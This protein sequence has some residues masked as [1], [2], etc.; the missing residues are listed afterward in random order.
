MPT[1]EIYQFPRRRQRRSEQQLHRAVI[2]HLRWRAA[3]DVWFAHYPGGGYR[4]P[5][6]AAIL[7]SLGTREGVPDLLIVAPEVESGKRAGCKLYCIELKSSTGKLSPSQRAC[8]AELRR[9]GATVE[10]VS[11]IDHALEL[12]TAWGILPEASS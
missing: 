4:R 8:H 7:K 12:L 9:A 11:D 6:E 1:Q 3:P 5:I 10:T 2:E